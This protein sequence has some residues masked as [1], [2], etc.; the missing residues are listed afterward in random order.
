MAEASDAEVE[1]DVGLSS[2]G[3]SA[4]RWKSFFV[5]PGARWK[6]RLCRAGGGGTTV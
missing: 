4:L 1:G 5:E 2:S 3:T 6:V